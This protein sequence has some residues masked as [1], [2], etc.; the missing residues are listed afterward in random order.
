MVQGPGSRDWSLELR[1]RV[2]GGLWFGITGLMLMV[3]GHG[4][5]FGDQSFGFRVYD[6]GGRVPGLGSKVWIKVLGFGDLGFRFISKGLGLGFGD[7]GYR[8]IS[9]G[10][11]IWGLGIW[12]SG[13]YLRVWGSPSDKVSEV[14]RLPNSVSWGSWL[15]AW[16]Y[17][18]KVQGVWCRIQ[19]VGFGV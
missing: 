17:E 16:G 14:M 3:Y 11:G 8:F 19:G 12:V 1:V 7:S 4:L 13:S 5:G 9:K 18:F 10:L 2:W 15:S 6:I